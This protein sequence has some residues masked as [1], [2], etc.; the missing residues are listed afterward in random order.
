MPSENVEIVR[1]V[2]EAQAERDLHT[3]FSQYDPAIEWDVTRTG[4]SIAGVGPIPKGHDGVRSWFRGWQEPF[5]D[6]EYEIEELLEAGEDVVAVVRQSGR[7][8]SSGA[9]T[10]MMLY[11]V[12]TI[13]HRRVTRVVWFPDRSAAL[14]AAG[15]PDSE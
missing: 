15:I 13:R 10:V 7:G 14:A 5:E 1:S 2:I 11:G 6:V 9:I 3:I 12:W 8:R 4:G